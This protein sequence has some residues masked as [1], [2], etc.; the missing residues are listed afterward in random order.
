MQKPRI[1]LAALITTPLA[2]VAC[3]QLLSY[4]DY[5][6]RPDL[7]VDTGT[8]PVDAS[9]EVSDSSPDAGE[10]PLRPPLRPAGERK[11]SGKGKR[12]YFAVKRMYLGSLTTLGAETADAWK[13][14]GLDIDSLCTSLSDSKANIGTCKR[15]ADAQQD[16]LVD[17][18]RC[19]DNNFGHH[20]IG[21]IKLSSSGFEQRL[22]DGLLDGDNT[23]IV[24]IDDLDDGADDAYA[25]AKM[26]RSANKSKPKWDGTEAL[27]VLSDSVLGDSLET[28][29]VEF[30]NGFVKD[31]VWVSGDPELREFI[32]PISDTTLVP[33]TLD[34]ATLSFELKPDHS[35]GTRGVLAGAIPLA[36]IDKLLY[37]VAAGAGICPGSGLY[38]SL[39]NSFQRFPDVVIGAPKLQDTTQQCNGISFGIGM[40]VS[41]VQP[42]TTLVA[43]PAP[44]PDKC[45]AGAKPG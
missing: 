23:W 17:G 16:S 37:P 33:L 27:E 40:D 44:E 20:V 25:P 9:T 7:P 10:T 36:S 24:R 42:S 3:A 38:Q 29:R 18:L 30:P 43:P 11:A 45:D 12:I 1:A 32:L 4:D 39:W 41:P 35:T 28:A 14:W 22:N 13:D 8:A 31:N 19:R 26:Y 34:A 15:P 2:F 5:S 6:P 21:L